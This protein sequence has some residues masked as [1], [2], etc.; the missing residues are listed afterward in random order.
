[1]DTL[2]ED[3]VLLKLGVYND[4]TMTI[5][6]FQ[7]LWDKLSEPV[8][9]KKVYYEGGFYVAGEKISAGDPIYISAMTEGE[10]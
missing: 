7:R 6:E 8:K 9:P 5:D 10:G 3:R 1:M 2:E 4:I